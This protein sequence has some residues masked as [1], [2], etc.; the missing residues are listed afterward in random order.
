MKY[1]YALIF[2]Q[3]LYDL[4]KFCFHCCTCL[5]S[6]LELKALLLSLFFIYFIYFSFIYFP[7]Y[8][9]FFSFFLSFFYFLFLSVLFPFF[10]FLLIFLCITKCYKKFSATNSNVGTLRKN[11]NITLIMYIMKSYNFLSLKSVNTATVI[12][13]SDFFMLSEQLRYLKS[14]LVSVK[15][16]F[17]CCITIAYSQ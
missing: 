14:F 9:S 11:T 17:N 13:V 12:V 10:T 16:S 2:G 8:L 3:I 7:F 4:K 1:L 5:P 15:F 6:S